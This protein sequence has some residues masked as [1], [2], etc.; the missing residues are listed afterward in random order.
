M[1][2]SF[3]QAIARPSES[4]CLGFTCSLCGDKSAIVV[5]MNAPCSP[6]QPDMPLLVTAA[7]IFDAGKV[8]VTRRPEHKRHPGLWEFPG[9]KIDPGESPET[10]LIREIDEELGAEV[11]VDRIYEVVYYRYAWGP[12]LILA[13]V[14]RL[15]TGLLR[16]LG[17]AEHRWVH[18]QDLAE[19][20]FL[21][22]DQ[23][24]IDRLTDSPSQGSLS[25]PL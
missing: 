20:A 3:R 2:A 9:G 16:N 22:A 8:L 11:S 10:A 1:P 17:V 4:I 21:P 5:A 19:M 23:P 13:Y 6:D 25:Q 24:I 18:P 7:I 15:R 14:C 12:V